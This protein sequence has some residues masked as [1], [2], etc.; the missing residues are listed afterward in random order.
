[1][2]TRK[3]LP[4]RKP[5]VLIDEARVISVG[6]DRTTGHAGHRPLA[7]VADEHDGADLGAENVDGV[8][9]AGVA[10]AR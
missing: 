10:G 9:P 8:G 6:R 5:G 4:A 2:A 1:M 3:K 7:D